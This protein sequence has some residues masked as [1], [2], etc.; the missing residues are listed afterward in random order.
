MDVSDDGYPRPRVRPVRTPGFSQER[1]REDFANPQDRQSP[2]T[3]AI[4]KL[5][6]GVRLGVTWIVYRGGPGKVTFDP[7][8]VAVT[9]TTDA[10]GSDMSPLK[11][12]ATTNVIFTEPGVYHLRAYADDGVLTTPQDLTITV[13]PR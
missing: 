9:K 4:V 13:Q 12:R 6:P 7:M 2:A 5:D 3:Q 11:G 1:N 10:A 8:R